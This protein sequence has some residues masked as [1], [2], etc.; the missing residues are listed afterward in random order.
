MIGGH[1]RR[2]EAGE[3]QLLDGEAPPGLWD[4]LAAQV[5]ALGFTVLRVSDAGQ[6]RGADGLTDY[7][8]RQVSVRTDVM[9]VNQVATLA[10]ELVHVL[11]HD[12]KDEEAR[13]HRG[14]REVEAESVAL[15]IGAAHGLDTG[16]YTIPYV[17]G[18]ASSVKD[19]EPA[20]VVKATG[21]LNDRR[22]KLLHAHLEG[23][24][25]LELLKEEQDKI[26]R[27]LALLDAQINSGDIEYD[28]AKAHL[29]DCLT[30]AGNCHQLY[31]SLDDSVRRIANQAFFEKLYIQ[32]GDVIDGRPGEPF[33][34][35][36]NQ[37]VQRLAVERQRAVESGNQTGQIDGLNIDHLVG[38][39]GFELLWRRG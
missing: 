25:P 10:H 16:G 15:M 11:M 17:A 39:T 29:D 37:D 1:R 36:F 32:P 8:T 30:L 9:E 31:L 34:I 7:M 14:I 20:E 35:F 18:W 19:A 24:V 13:R 28:Q 38:V 5:E 12:P 4:G 2:E 33:T 22:T 27:R 23:G 3:F 26:A 21:E 6:I